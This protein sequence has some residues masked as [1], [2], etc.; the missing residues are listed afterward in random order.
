MIRVLI[1]DDEPPARFRVR[2]LLAGMGDVE[3][4]AETTSGRDTLKAL[5]EQRPDLLFLDVQMPPPSGVTLLRE[6]APDAR[7]CTIFTTAHEDHALDAF[8]LRAVDYLLKPF[9]GERFHDALSRAREFL[10]MTA[11]RRPAKLRRLL[12]REGNSYSIVPTDEIRLIESA[13]NYVVVHTAEKREVLRRTMAS[14]E[15]DLDPAQF[16]RVNRAAIVNLL[17]VRAIE[18]V[19]AEEH[20]LLLEGGLR[21]PLSRGVRELQARIER[22]PR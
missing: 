17:F 7:P 16:V 19:A 3:I 11:T 22:G 8:A 12:A 21:V 10:E 9:T 5:R 2:E 13:N 14:L 1:A 15:E 6:L 4:I 18:G 20:V